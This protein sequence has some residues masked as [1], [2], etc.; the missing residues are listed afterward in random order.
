MA[1]YQK[2]RQCKF[3]TDNRVELDYKNIDLLRHFLSNYS[4]IISKKRTG[5]CAKHQRAL[6][7]AIKRARFMSLL[8]Y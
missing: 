6:A 2:K 7:Q 8:P 3:C 4:K 5:V 1:F